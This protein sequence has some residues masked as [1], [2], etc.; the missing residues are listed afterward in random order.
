MEE[1]QVFQSAQFGQVRTTIR[2]GEPWFVA[3]D[4]CK[5]LEI[6][7]PSQAL[8]N[9]DDDEKMTI[10]NNEG[11]SG[12]R[13]GAQMMNIINEPGLYSLVIRSRKPEAKAFKRWITHE[14]IPSIRKSGGYIAGQSTMSDA[15]LMAKALLVA[16]RQIEQRDKQITEMQPKALFADAVSASKSSILIG[17]LAKM[18]RQNGVDIGQNRLFEYLRENGYLCKSGAMYNCPTQ[19]AMDMGLFEI[20][21]T[22]IQHADGHVTI[23]RTPKVTGKGQVYFVNKLLGGGNDE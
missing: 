5:V 16:Q 23:N 1:I 6:G 13:G 19:R 21:E 17:E 18:L 11:H 20:K 15:D 2:D 8:A 3:A 22:A 7:N 9:L 14:V 10:S 4:V 12:Q